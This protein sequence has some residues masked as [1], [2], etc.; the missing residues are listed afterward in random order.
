MLC[1]NKLTALCLLEST[2]GKLLQCKLR[3][4]SLSLAHKFIRQLATNSIFEVTGL[5]IEATFLLTIQ[6]CPFDQEKDG[7][8]AFVIKLGYGKRLK[9]IGGLLHS[10]V[11][12]RNQTAN[13][14]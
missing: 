6:G 11:R 9:I 10:E 14:S 7:R 12:F 5:I 2:L 4:T 8:H 3:T 1:P 13:I